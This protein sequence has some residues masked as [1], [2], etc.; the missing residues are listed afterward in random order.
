MKLLSVMMCLSGLILIG[1]GID[2]STRYDRVEE[3][4]VRTLAFIYDNN[5]LAEGAPG[6]TVLCTV[7]FAGE[8]VETIDF[9][10]SSSLIINQFGVDTFADTVSLSRYLVPGTY[11]E[12]FGGTTDSVQFQFVVPE[13]VIRDQFADDATIGSLLPPGVADT[14][15]PDI[16]RGIKAVDIIDTIESMTERPAVVPEA[17]V[18]S[19]LQ[20]L[21]VTMKLF[22]TANGTYRMES[23][24]SVRYNA[25]LASFIPG[26]PMN[27][28]PE[29]RWVRCFRT[30]GSI[31]VFDPKTHKDRIDTV[32]NLY[33]QGD[34]ILVDNGYQYFLVADSTPEIVDSGYSITDSTFTPEP[35]QLSYEWFYENSETETDVDLDSLMALN[36]SFGGPSVE[37]LPPLRP[38]F[39]RFSLWLVVYDEF[40]GEKLRPV[41]FDLKCISGTYRYSAAYV[42]RHR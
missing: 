40:L 13:D 27:H 24:F 2:F 42:K 6:D 41:G 32:F 35:E 31:G 11:K 19:L 7:Y 14:V 25:R 29:V 8:P 30:T 16:F 20:V 5:G 4:R 26:I 18:A 15:L 34:T 1:C 38:E 39:E 21:T 37:L 28:N 22:A 9:T 12:Y 17:V 33:P 3:N 23:T 10:V 36:N